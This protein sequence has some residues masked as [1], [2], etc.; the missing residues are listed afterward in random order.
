MTEKNTM[1]AALSE[2]QAA[3]LIIRN[4]LNIMT[5]KQKAEWA[6]QNE[7]DGCSGEGTTRANERQATIE[8]LEADAH[9]AACADPAAAVEQLLGERPADV[10]E[11]INSAAE[12]LGWLEEIFIIIKDDAADDRK[13]CRVEKMAAV[14]AYIA[15]D[16]ANY[17]GCQYE[18]YREQ[19]QKAGAI[20]SKAA[21]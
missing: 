21:I 8:L 11:T 9:E 7:A 1:K 6:R 17:A 15:F 19:L 16:Y 12:A 2:L 4:A 14:G 20:D 13:R 18:E 3:H 5:P 10:I